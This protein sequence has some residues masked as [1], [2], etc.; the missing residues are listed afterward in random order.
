MFSFASEKWFFQLVLRSAVTVCLADPI[1]VEEMLLNG[2]H[3]VD[4]VDVI[5]FD[6]FVSTDNKFQSILFR[7]WFFVVF[8]SVAHSQNVF[9]RWSQNCRHFDAVVD[10][11]LLRFLPKR[12]CQCFSRRHVDNCRHFEDVAASLRRQR[13]CRTF[14]RV[15]RRR[16][17]AVSRR[18][19]AVA[20]LARGLDPVVVVVLGPEVAVTSDSK[21]GTRVIRSFW[22]ILQNVNNV[23]KTKTFWFCLLIQIQP[24]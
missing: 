8:N 17:V 5:R 2:V 19:P 22:F 20:A 10:T 13:H 3:N 15:L 14:E 12:C 21:V 24:T 16:L 23:L 18:R 7:I 11:N 4:V 6:G 9:L 1:V